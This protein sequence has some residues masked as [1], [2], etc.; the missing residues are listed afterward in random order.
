[1]EWT[2]ALWGGFSSFFSIWQICILQ[3]SPFFMVY[4]LGLYLTTDEDSRINPGVRLLLPP[5][6]YMIGFSIIYA[7]LSARGI[8]AGRLLMSN[9]NNLRIAAGIFIG[10]ISLHFV[11]AARL[12]DMNH[13]LWPIVLGLGPLLLGISFALIYSPC[14][15]PTYAKILQMSVASE[16]AGQGARLALIYG[17]GM[18]LSFSV[19]GLALIMIVRPMPA[20][21]KPLLRN[22]SAAVLGVL[23]LMNITGVMVYYKAFFLGLLV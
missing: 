10:I 1:V 15:T 19:V 12:R 13:L 16:T 4:I 20:I 18:G 9:I 6:L 23:A 2:T 7:L 14:V 3:I 21:Y 22:F 11:L 5:A 17:L 8:S